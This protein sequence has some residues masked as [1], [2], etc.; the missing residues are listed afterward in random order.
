MSTRS[1]ITTNGNTKIKKIVFGIIVVA[2]VTVSALVGVIWCGKSGNNGKDVVTIGA[3]LPL[4]GKFA[5]NGNGVR[6][7]LEFAI[8]DINVAGK[9]NYQIKYFDTQSEAK[10]ALTGYTKLKTINKINIMFTTTSDHAL[11]LKPKAIEDGVL[12][13]CLA[14]HTDITKHNGQLVFRFTTLNADDA[15]CLARY[16]LDSLH[17]KRVFLYALNNE[18][19]LDYEKAIREK[20]ATNLIGTTFYD[21]DTTA[22]R[23]LATANTY[24]DAD[25]IAIFGHTPAM[26]FLIKNIREGG[27]IGPVIASAAF[28]QPSILTT[29]GDYLQTI[30]FV[31]C[32][33]PFASRQHK[34]WD[35]EAQAEYKF[36]FTVM[37][38]LTYSVL[39]IFNNIR[40]TGCFLPQEIG[41][42]LN[43]PNTY[44]INAGEETL[45]LT[46]NDGGIA[47][48][49]FMR[50]PSNIN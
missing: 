28:N 12:L 26:G 29:V 19:G 31:E 20:I 9:V 13:F 2:T 33:F 15:E 35:E 41:K 24:K 50:T 32:D 21:E 49:L 22:L 46:T 27:Y 42:R 25:C 4:T 40:S 7:G 10:N 45:M 18:A 1:T 17:S 5:D 23:N 48:R 34:M 44:L 37:S 43:E 6:V 8:R 11:I 3:V 47:P 36:S 30:S 16:A 38:Y 14:P 39:H